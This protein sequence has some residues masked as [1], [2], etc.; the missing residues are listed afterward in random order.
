MPLIGM[1]TGEVDFSELKLI[2]SEPIIVGDKVMKAGASIY[3]GNQIPAH[4]K[5]HCCQI[6]IH[7]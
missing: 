2:L 3:Y 5:S 7:S 6:N 1:D 4:D